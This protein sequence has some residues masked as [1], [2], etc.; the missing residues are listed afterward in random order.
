MHL[1]YICIYQGLQ[2]KK[3]VCENNKKNELKMFYGGHFEF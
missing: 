2:T 1:K 3:I